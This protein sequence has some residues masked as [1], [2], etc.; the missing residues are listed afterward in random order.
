MFLAMWSWMP[1]FKRKKRM[2]LNLLKPK[3]ITLS[4]VN[5]VMEVTPESQNLDHVLKCHPTILRSGHLY[6]K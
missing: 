6:H 5:F 2:T 4:E 1:I 3:F